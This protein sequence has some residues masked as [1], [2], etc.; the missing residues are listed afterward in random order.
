MK[1]DESTSLGEWQG[2]AAVMTSSKIKNGQIEL[3][4]VSN[5]RRGKNVSDAHFVIK[6]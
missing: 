1:I 5:A 3:K 4:F 2:V 6:C